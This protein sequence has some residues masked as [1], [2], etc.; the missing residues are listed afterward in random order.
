MAF[1]HPETNLAHLQITPG[2]KVADI[3]AG[4]GAYSFALS[5]MVGDNGRVYAIDVQKELLE[6]L[7]G[8]TR[9]LH[10][11]NIE[12]IWADAEKANG[13]KLR[14]N[15]LDAAVL[16]NILFQVENKKGVSDEVRRILKPGG[17]ILVIDW[18][19]SFDGL[20]PPQRDVFPKEQAAALLVGSGF[21]RVEEYDA[22]DHHYG[23]IF[24][25]Q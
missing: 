21:V 20:G 24:K 2:M 17:K 23:L 13:T 15:W 4:A 5:Q 14:D 16:S 18:S 25:K 7:K 12:I 11:N 22:G 8:E 1:A 19:D 9:R 6:K 10:K 3:G